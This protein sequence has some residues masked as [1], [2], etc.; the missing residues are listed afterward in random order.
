MKPENTAVFRKFFFLGLFFSILFLS[1]FRNIY[2]SSG[3]IE[4][5]IP[6][7]GIPALFLTVLVAAVILIPRKFKFD[8]D[9]DVLFKSTAQLFSVY[10]L[11]FL[12]LAFFLLHRFLLRIF[13][14]PE[15]FRASVLFL[16]I[17]L[18][19]FGYMAGI[20]F[21]IFLKQIKTREQYECGSNGFFS[22]FAAGCILILSFLFYRTGWMIFL[23]SVSGFL[24][25]ELFFILE[26]RKS[27]HIAAFSFVSLI[28]LAISVLF[29][30][31]NI[32]DLIPYSME[33]SSGKY[34]LARSGIFF[35]GKYEPFQPE[36]DHMLFLAAGLQNPK[37]GK[38]ILIISNENMSVAFSSKMMPFAEKTEFLTYSPEFAGLLRSTHPRMQ[39]H[40]ENPFSFLKKNRKSYDLILL[41]TANYG[42]LAFQNLYSLEMFRSIREDLDQE[43]VFAMR[44]LPP[45]HKNKNADRILYSTVSKV[46]PHVLIADGRNRFLLASDRQLT[47]S[48][49]IFAKRMDDLFVSSGKKSLLPKNLFS[50]VGSL[51]QNNSFVIDGSKISSKNI[52]TEENPL[53]LYAFWKNIPAFK[54]Q[55]IMTRI[56]RFVIRHLIVILVITA[57]FYLLIRY[58]MTNHLERK[59]L[60]RGFELGMFA[61]GTFAFFCILLQMRTSRLYSLIT[62]LSGFFALGCLLRKWIFR[63]KVRGSRGFVFL[64]GLLPFAVYW[65]SPES[66]HLM[67]IIFLAGTFFLGAFFQKELDSYDL[68]DITWSLFLP[69]SVLTGGMTGI[70]LLC[71]IQ[72]CWGIFSA[73]IFL[74]LLRLPGMI[75]HP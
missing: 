8:T 23:P 59:M 28:F 48:P 61:F 67:E 69:V 2:S 33:S 12:F 19:A 44:L 14:L 34:E 25:L 36:M 9:S 32:K 64:S 27:I 73:M 55:M 52:M 70:L 30:F 41:C 57:G 13:F 68:T 47:L 10:G 22:G 15:Y 6:F 35:N 31:I 72:P 71:L 24:L 21:G 53:L 60:F 37:S 49:E 54:G 11:V 17:F 56:H 16:V 42:S 58:F 1:F 65:F 51:I 43:G 5:F 75:R 38:R 74:F 3:G 18:F 66:I 45:S 7:F 26:F 62:L 39:I 63:T 46:F 40:V 29:I 4:L 50:V 20:I